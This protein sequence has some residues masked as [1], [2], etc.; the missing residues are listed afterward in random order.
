MNSITQFSL[1]TLAA[2][3]MTT[4]ALA[5]G[6]PAIPETPAPVIDLVSATP[7]TLDAGYQHLW[8]AEKETV[9]SGYILVLEVDPDLVIPRQIAEPVLYVGHQTAERI[10]HG[11]KSGHVIAIVPGVLDDPKHP[12][13]IDL[14]KALI[15]FGTPELP[16][17]VDAEMIEQEHA[18]A[19][20][21]GIRPFAGKQLAAARTEGGAVLNVT[22]KEDLSDQLATLIRTYSPQEKELLETMA[23]AQSNR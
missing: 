10:N 12:D 19:V 6:P 16:E 18:M 4:A 7:F 23:P 20:R 15:W 3:I 8:S 21:S 9:S 5:D 1:S 11:D 22:K 17:R 2:C 13:Y 14:D